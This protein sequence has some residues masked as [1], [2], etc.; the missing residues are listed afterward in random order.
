[1]ERGADW[2]LKMPKTV[3]FLVCYTPLASLLCSV[4]KLG[5]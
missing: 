2:G 5:L 3:Y 1:M 4:H